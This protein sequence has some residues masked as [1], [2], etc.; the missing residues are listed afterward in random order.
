MGRNAIKKKQ[1][2]EAILASAYQ[3]FTTVGFT[4]TT[5]TAITDMAGV[6][7]GTFYLYF[8]S[9]EHVRDELIMIKSSQ[10]LSRALDSMRE[11]VASAGGR[12]GVS[13]RMLY[14]IDY[15]LQQVSEDRDL[16]TFVAKNLSWGLLFNSGTYRNAG[17]DVLDFR[18]FVMDSFERDGI[19]LREPLLLF[20]TII[21]LVS[22][23]CYSIILSG[24][25]VTMEE[26]R[27]Y[28]HRAIRLLIEDAIIKDVQ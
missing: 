12:I 3:L 20:Y 26:Y 17:S 18:A 1:K 16:L 23:A 21:E 22:S 13:D 28:L 8:E 4:N 10:V 24:D 15:I 27:P 11:Y 14:V 6:A 25:P 2:R 19:E 5:I 9:K 7:K